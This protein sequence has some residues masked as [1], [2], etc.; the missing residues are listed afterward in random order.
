MT[1][2]SETHPIWERLMKREI[3]YTF[4]LFAANMAV[5]YAVRSYRTDASQKLKLAG[6]LRDFFSKYERIALPE[7][8]RLI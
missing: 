6:E 5:D 2:P 8:E 4:S 3:T 7:L 1:L